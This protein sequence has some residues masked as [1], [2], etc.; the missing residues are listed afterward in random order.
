M[1]CRYD[2]PK[3]IVFENLKY[4]FKFN[5]DFPEPSTVEVYSMKK[6]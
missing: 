1:I 4:D 6:K 2:Y 3:I 5:E